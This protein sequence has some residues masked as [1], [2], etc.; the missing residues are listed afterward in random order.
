M[1]KG[2]TPYV[3]C[4]SL[5]HFYMCDIKSRRGAVCEEHSKVSPVRSRAG[6][7]QQHSNYYQEPTCCSSSN[8]LSL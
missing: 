8:R 6:A 1:M 7:Q 5:A 4:L 3:E 2:A